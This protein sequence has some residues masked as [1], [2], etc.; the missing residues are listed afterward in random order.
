MM[1]LA[2]LLLASPVLAG[3]LSNTSGAIR[4]QLGAAPQSGADPSRCYLKGASVPCVGHAYD[5]RVGSVAVESQGSVIV[6]RDVLQAMIR[7]AEQQGGKLAVTVKPDFQRDKFGNLKPSPC[8]L[9]MQEAMK[10]AE[11]NHFWPFVSVTPGDEG[12]PTVVITDYGCDELCR[13]KKHVKE[14]E[15]KQK[16]NEAMWEARKRWNATMKECVAERD[17]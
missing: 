13:A 2:L 3:E 17:R 4:V 16:Q 1:L 5:Q 14:L 12:W 11:K 15:D 6:D 10:D 9:R 7:E 8:Y